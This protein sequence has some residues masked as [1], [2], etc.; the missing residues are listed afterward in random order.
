MRK[1]RFLI[2]I[3]SIGL[4]LY[5]PPK[6][7][8]AQASVGSDLNFDYIG[9]IIVKG[10]QRIEIET[11][12]SYMAVV[13]GDPFDA[14]RINQS[15]KNLYATGLFSDVV[16]QRE[17]EGL[18]V[19]VT[20]N[21]L[22]N[23]IAFEGNNEIKDEDLRK[24]IQ[25]KERVVYTR[26]RA[27][28]DAQTLV[29]LYRRT[30]W[31]AATIEPKII[32]LE[33]NRVNLVFEINEGDQTSINRI[34]FIGNR[35]FSDSN[36][37]EIIT[38]QESRWYRFFA[39]NDSYDPDRLA[40]D[41]EQLRKYYLNEG[42]ADFSVS[43]AVAELTE[44]QK[45]FFI[46]FTVKEGARYRF[47]KI[48]LDTQI[49]DLD[50]ASLR[51]VLTSQEGEWYDAEEVE[52]SISRLTD[53]LGTFGYAFVDIRP[54]VER[55]EENRLINLTYEIG[56]GPKVF[57]ERINIRGNGQTIDEVI[58]RE[59][60]L[61][62]GDAF[63]T[64]KLRRSRQRIESLGYFGKVDIQTN[65]GS[66][67]DR[68][69]IDVEVEEKSTGDLS[70]GVAYSTSDGVVGKI[71]IKERNFMG[72]G[73]EL[74]LN[75]QGSKQTQN[76][77]LG[78]TEP[79]F[80][81]R[82]LSAGFD[83]FRSTRDSQNSSSYSQAETGGGLRIGYSI[84]ERLAQSFRYTLKSVNIK[85]VKDTASEHIKNQK[86]TNVL[87]ELSSTL[88]YDKRDNIFRP[89]DGY[90]S[91][92]TTDFAGI[93]GDVAYTRFRMDSGY[94]LTLLEDVVMSFK[95]EAG[96]IFGI[97]K[98]IRL[99]DRFFLG[100]N[101]IRGFSVSG[102]GPRDRETND[103]I[104]GTSYYSA[105]LELKFPVGFPDELGVKGRAFIDAGSLFGL[106]S[107]KIENKK[108]IAGDSAS[109]RTSIGLGIGWV[110]PFGPINLDYAFPI[111]KESSDIVEK[112]R[113]SFGTNF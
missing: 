80:L 111:T 45:S 52:I 105:V 82:P 46:T 22:V 40:F 14:E 21:S 23:R 106:N 36:L 67:E 81:D 90:F 8:V 86:G 43:S 87:S 108:A 96:T 93:I 29:E 70:F 58:R 61:A 1:F 10:A 2:G 16:L 12:K 34:A 60:R 110:S 98:D 6:K 30:G 24:Q 101:E 50:I 92:L 66:S 99:S 18:I 103:S 35:N 77:D 26:A 63:N 53:R 72:K 95:L 3:L 27:Q 20:E 5:A 49:P 54:R 15:L 73:Q 25:S 37:R 51:E 85:D 17:E 33:Q 78:F 64:S 84:S 41:Q 31:F 44:D 104:G 79:Y 65:P 56:E 47:G 59:F 113:I 71:G 76:I 89:G 100:S 7:A 57:V 68:T 39:S 11:I 69:I 19:T 94:Y 91:R 109:P 48:N 107:I 97:G 13:P 38:T 9:E 112:F 102:L 28:Q 75:Y 32:R 88:V 74:R 62:E 4:C 55:D 83:L 42:Y